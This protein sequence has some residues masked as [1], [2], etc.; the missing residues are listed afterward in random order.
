MTTVGG[1]D[2]VTTRPDPEAS[3]F[4]D[5][6]LGQQMDDMLGSIGDSEKFGLTD[7]VHSYASSLGKI[8]EE[9]EEEEEED[10]G[11]SPKRLQASAFGETSHETDFEPAR[12]RPRSS[13][14]SQSSR[15]EVTPLSK[16]DPVDDPILAT[17]SRNAL[18]RE[19]STRDT[20]SE[21]DPPPSSHGNLR[22][23]AAGSYGRRSIRTWAEP[24][25]SSVS[26]GSEPDS[27]DNSPHG[28]TEDVVEPARQSSPLPVAYEEPLGKKPPDRTGQRSGVGDTVLSPSV[29]D[30]APTGLA[31]TDEEIMP[32][33]W[34][35]SE[36]GRRSRRR[37]MSCTVESTR[38]TDSR[39]PTTLAD[40]SRLTSPPGSPAPALRRPPILKRPGAQTK[41]TSVRFEFPEKSDESTPAQSSRDVTA[42][43]RRP[44]M[45]GVSTSETG[46]DQVDT[47]DSSV[48]AAPRTPGR[49]SMSHESKVEP[50]FSLFSKDGPGDVPR[51]SLEAGADLQITLASTLS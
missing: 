26:E 35:R 25:L 44:R 16:W 29:P 1:L 18:T 37:S 51:I 7:Y 23:G 46:A 14:L 27:R 8:Q 24:N 36:D 28:V 3:S 6:G 45:S 34:E 5:E 15:E 9:E 4:L 40:S 21:D 39:R 32:G 10:D 20:E 43:R 31:E 2:Y 38:L 22:G 49:R 41:D 30:T 17:T 33:R 42:E 19:G 13:A 50:T 47:G 12:K 11:P 48:P